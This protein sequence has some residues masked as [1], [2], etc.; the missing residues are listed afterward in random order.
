[1]LSALINSFRSNHFIIT[2]SKSRLEEFELHS[3]QQEQLTPKNN[4]IERQNGRTRSRHISYLYENRHPASLMNIGIYELEHFES[5][6]PLIRLLDRPENR[7]FLFVSNH[8]QQELVQKLSNT[9][10][11]IEWI[12]KPEQQSIRKFLFKIESETQKHRFLYLF[13]HTVSSN[14]LFFAYLIFRIHDQTGVI[15]TL[16]DVNNLF[17]SHFTFHPRRLIRHIGKRLLIRQCKH[18]MTISESVATYLKTLVKMNT[19]VQWFPGGLFEPE[20]YKTPEPITNGL[21]LVVPGSVDPKRRNY[22]E[23]FQLIELLHANNI[24]I[25]IR[26]L[27]G[28]A[29]LENNDLLNKC[30]IVKQSYPGFNFYESTFVAGNEYEEQLQKAHFVWVPSVLHTTIADNIEELYGLSKSSGTLFDAIRFARPVLSPIELKTDQHQSAAVYSYSNL[31][32]LLLFIKG[33]L[34]APQTYNMW[35]DRAYETSCY[36]QIEQLR[37]TVS[38]A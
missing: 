15:V 28:F 13:L 29:D 36:Y 33:N 30:R 18:Y 19:T 21:Q 17:Q 37:T 26:L 1:M 27:G 7:L 31:N 8:V 2:K 10:A 35:K 4:D 34:N 16:H 24:H 3:I 11:T 12:I 6:Y 20:Q 14:H 9:Q 5:V 32:D 25:V 38:I 23:V 22:E